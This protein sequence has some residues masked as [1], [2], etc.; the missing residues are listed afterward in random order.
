MII[1]GDKIIK[2]DLY[3]DSL[4][5]KNL[6]ATDSNGKVIESSVSFAQYGYIQF[7]VGDGDSAITAGTKNYAAQIPYA[8]TITG[9][10]IE[11]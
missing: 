10:Y 4:K 8:G 7:E 3:L 9:W 2:K 5:S 11:Y 1:Q 6:L